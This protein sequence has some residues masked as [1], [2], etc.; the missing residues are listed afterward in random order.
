MEVVGDKYHPKY[1]LSLAPEIKKD[2]HRCKPFDFIGPPRHAEMRTGGESLSVIGDYISPAGRDVQLDSSK[3]VPPRGEAAGQ[4][5]QLIFAYDQGSYCYPELI[6]KGGVMSDLSSSMGR[7][8]CVWIRMVCAGL[9]ASIISTGCQRQADAPQHSNS[10]VTAKPANV[11]APIVVQMIEKETAALGLKPPAV[12]LTSEKAKVARQAVLRGDYAQADRIAADVLAHSQLQAWRFY[13]FSLF[14]KTFTLGTEPHL[15]EHL[16]EWVDLEPAAAIPPLLRAR[17][18]QQAAGVARGGD[19][20]GAVDPEDM[21]TYHSELQ[22]AAADAR[23]SIRNDGRN[24]YAWAILVHTEGGSANSSAAEAVFQEAIKQFPDYYNFY[25]WRLETLR[26]KWGGSVEE[27]LAFTRHYAGKAPANSPLK[28]LYLKL[29]VNLLDAARFGSCRRQSGDS[30][31]QC[32]AEGI[33]SLVSTDLAEQIQHALNLY[34]TSDP[35]QFNLAAAG[36]FSEIAQIAGKAPSAGAILQQAALTM[37]SELQLIEE[38]PGHNNYL[39][40][41]IAAQ[42]WQSSRNYDKAEHKYQEALDDIQRFK[43]SDEEDKALATADI[44]S[45]L[46][47]LADTTGRYEKTIVY[48]NAVEMLGGSRFDEAFQTR[49]SAWRQLKQY[50]EAVRECSRQIQGDGDTAATRFQRA[51]AYTE[52][53]QW[54]AAAADYQ[55]VADSESDFRTAA[56]INWAYAVFEKGDFA[57]ALAVMGAHPLMF[58]EAHEEP[59]SLA[60]AFNNRCYV[61]KKMGEL[62]KALDDCTTSLKYGRLPDALQKQQ[63]LL[64]QIASTKAKS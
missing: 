62:Q 60:M 55:R 6:S 64:R 21:R 54:D 19:I 63:E 52:L 14:V 32:I 1:Q 9:V 41:I 36:L 33:N 26:P 23:L 11:Q 35:M 51:Y 30:L 16:N 42:M 20:A 34:K 38:H 5:T 28:L 47:K 13:P 10:T 4:I 29:Y 17:Y 59:E 39:V 7:K 58:D 25:E 57:G 22:S 45:L 44:Y 8:H 48:R 56:A 46:A 61:Y 27:M 24:P 40:D 18:H 3:F 53:K 2:L 50:D 31:D 15:L 49:C 43:F 12:T 37:N